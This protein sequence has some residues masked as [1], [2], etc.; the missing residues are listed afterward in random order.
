MPGLLRAGH[1]TVEDGEDRGCMLDNRLLGTRMYW[2]LWQCHQI[3][4][5][6][7][8][9]SNQILGF[10]PLPEFDPIPEL[11]EIYGIKTPHDIA[12]FLAM[13][14]NCASPPLLLV[15]PH[16]RHVSNVGF[17][18]GVLVQFTALHSG[19]TVF[20]QALNQRWKNVQI[21][22]IYLCYFFSGC[23]NILSVYAQTS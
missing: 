12:D 7:Q 2:L 14:L 23:A 3:P 9:R 6:T 8:A 22:Q 15:A 16:P 1:N 19:L 10:I 11:S 17:D 13:S 21:L 18:S 4:C 5:V 20:L